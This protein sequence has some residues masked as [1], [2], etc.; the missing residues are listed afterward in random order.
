MIVDTSAVVAI[1]QGE[2]DSEALSS[3]ILADQEPKMSAAT[4]VELYAVAD[5]RGAPAEARRVDTLLKQL[6][7]RIVA[8]DEAQA[9]IAREAYRDFGRGSGHAAKLNLGDTFSYALAAQSGEPLLYVGNDF[10]QTD[11]RSALT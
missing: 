2:A 10:G 4:V 11:L 6:R 7:I 5:V 1:L 8:F 3:A 9:T